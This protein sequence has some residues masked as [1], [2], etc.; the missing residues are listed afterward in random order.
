MD[1][2]AF[3][4]LARLLRVPFMFYGRVSFG[5]AVGCKSQEVLSA[6]CPCLGSGVKV[7]FGTALGSTGTGT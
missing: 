4:F 3:E 5:V 6:F 7:G 1:T 2:V